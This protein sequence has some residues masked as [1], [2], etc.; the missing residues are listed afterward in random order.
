VTTSAREDQRA[1]LKRHV[2]FGGLGDGEIAELLAHAHVEH[3]N[4][5]SEIFAK[6]SPGQSVIAVLRGSVKISSPSP[7]GKE[8]VLNNINAGELFGEIALLDGGER[9]ADATAVED[10]ELLVVYRRDFLPLL[11]RRSDICVMLLEM[12]CQR[13]RQTSEQ[14]ED[15]LFGDL[16]GRVAKV[17]LRLAQAAQAQGDG[18][19]TLVLRVTQQELGSMAGGAR[20]SVNRQLQVWQTAGLI[21]LGKGSIS[22]CDVRR[23][24]RMI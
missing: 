7:D 16:G 6:G 12:L 11:K 15:V 1:L 23:L 24:Q 3:H 5:G 14:V 10:C 18:S 9:T 19:K 4:A 17:L 20:E 8:I 21:K 22:I 13:L 2:L